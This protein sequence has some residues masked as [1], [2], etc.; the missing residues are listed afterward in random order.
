MLE[1]E[2]QCL[3][4][5]IK[6]QQAVIEML[7]TNDKYTGQ[8]KTVKTKSKNNTNVASPSSVSQKNPSPIN[9]KNWFDNLIV[10]EVNQ[11]ENHEPQDHTPTNYHKH[12]EITNTNLRIKSRNK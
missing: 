2:N 10:N 8:R 11:I 3:I 4:N 9:L 1:K 12:C 5:E 6:N 7:I